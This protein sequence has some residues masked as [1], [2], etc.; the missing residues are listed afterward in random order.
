M[1]SARDG[2]LRTAWHVYNGE[3]DVERAL[4]LLGRRTAR[5]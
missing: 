3:E 4:E 1:A 5:E 2:L